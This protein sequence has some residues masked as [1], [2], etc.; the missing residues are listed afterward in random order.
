[1]GLGTVKFSLILATVG[2]TVE[3]C[4]FLEHLAQQT[5]GN[6]ELIVVDQNPE[7]VLEPLIR[8]YQDRFPLLHLR[9][10]RGLSR[11]RNV[12]L[13][14][15]FGDIVAFPDDDCWY[16]PD[17]L[18]KIAHVF[19]ENS[20]YDGFTGRG[21]DDSR[22]ADYVFFSRRS[23]WVNKK[24]VWRSGTSFSIFLRAS[25]IRAVGPFDESLGVGSESGKHSAEEVDYLIRA[26]GSGFRIYYCP[27]LCIFHP[28]PV[29]TY[30]CDLIKRGYRYSV[31]FGHVLSKHNYPFP[32]VFYYLLRAFGG[33]VASLLT[34]NFAKTRYHLAILKGR[35]LGWLG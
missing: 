26:I 14:R 1:M 10:E 23:G 18:E 15:F 13:Q 8:Q 11:A 17:T 5:Y 27:D 35:V 22:P 34:L 30:S 6:F 2:R 19:Y 20:N 31:G 3:L 28:Y 7:G 16:A 25:V 32:S 21:V 33:A 29:P 9:S 12:G 24:N 4:R